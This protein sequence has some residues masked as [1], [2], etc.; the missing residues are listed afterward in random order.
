MID[1]SLQQIENKRIELQASLDSIRTR[2]ERNRLGQFATPMPLAQEIMRHVS[3]FFNPDQKIR[4]ME[5]AFGTGSFY[6]ALLNTFEKNRIQKTIAYEIDAEYWQVARNLWEQTTLTLHLADFTR[7]IPPSPTAGRYNLVISNP[8]YVRHHHLSNQDKKRLQ[9]ATQNVFGKKLSGLAGLYCYFIGLSHDWMED[10]GIAGWLIP[11]EFM[12]VNYGG[13][14]RDYLTSKI[15]LLQIHRF[16]P[17]DT[18]FDDALVSSSVV[19]FKKEPPAKDHQVLFTYGGSLSKPEISR[20]L[21]LENLKHKEKWGR[22]TLNGISQRTD[23]ASALSNFFD[24]RRGLAT[25]ENKFFILT[26]EQIAARQIPW[27]F[28]K[29][30]LP[31]PRYLEVEDIQADE[32]GIP[33]INRQLFLL[34][35]NLPEREVSIQYPSLWNYYQEGLN[36]GIGNAYLCKHRKPWYSQEKREAPLFACTYVGRITEKKQSPFR[37][38]LNR[39]QATITNSFLGLYPKK[40]L[41]LAIKKRPDLIDIIW[42]KLNEIP[43]HLLI[44]EGRVYGGGMYKIEPKELGKVPMVQMSEFLR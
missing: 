33:L 16:N 21:P 19:F 38:I 41:H 22:I 36:N 13:V 26:R 30:I 35:C 17:D 43:P 27:Q 42:R 39:S 14:I 31:S 25:G 23:K 1:L 15:T 20:F 24:I 3:T 34:D 2:I 6:S 12:D 9:T 11:S 28:L 44:N 29:P 37:F 40:E 8:P 7:S 18:Q 5:P 32:K 4:F 10:G